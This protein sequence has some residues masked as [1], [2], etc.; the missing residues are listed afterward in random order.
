MSLFIH[1]R[2][3]V[4][5]IDKNNHELQIM[6][7]HIDVWHRLVELA[8]LA[9]SID[10][11]LPANIRCFKIAETEDP[12]RTPFE[13]YLTDS[14]DKEKFNQSALETSNSIL[15]FEALE[16]TLPEDIVTKELALIKS[17]TPLGF[18]N[19][20]DAAIYSAFKEMEVSLHTISELEIRDGVDGFLPVKTVY[21]EAVN[22]PI[23]YFM[24]NP[25]LAKQSFFLEATGPTEDTNLRVINQTRQRV[26]FIKQ[27]LNKDYDSVSDKEKQMV[28][29]CI[30]N[31]NGRKAEQTFEERYQNGW[32][33]YSVAN[34][35]D[36]I[37]WVQ[38]L[39]EEA[40]C[41]IKQ[42]YG[43]N[44]NIDPLSIAIVH[45]D[46]KTANYLL[47]QGFDV[48]KPY[49]GF[50][51]VLPQA[52]QKSWLRGCEDFVVKPIH[53]AAVT[54]S[55]NVVEV[56]LKHGANPDIETDRSMTAAHFAAMNEDI[57]TLSH[58]ASYNAKFDIE[59]H[60]RRIASEV[61]PE[62]PNSDKLFDLIENWRE[63]TLPRPDKKEDVSE[64]AEL[65]Q[66]KIPR[67]PNLEK[68]KNKETATLSSNKP[69]MK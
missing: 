63:G 6:P 46:A 32:I 20:V 43:H 12:L 44:S 26:Q 40:Q 15:L 8:S 21:S 28:V 57:K 33:A 34:N 66:I 51:E 45:N 1:E 61:L 47:E 11:N 23:D 53:W 22:V 62:G 25:T 36:S 69:S 64:K 50:P 38:F 9:R 60:Q 10:P 67:T 54:G 65:V 58:L 7:Q 41:N 42:K 35:K 3:K 55:Y 30:N 68:L 13:I 39:H 48:K 37:K 4:I 29:D 24:Q 59:N 5:D 17:A 52:Q 31:L 16:K 49:F 19:T 56:L 27:T 18:I 14:K 2:A